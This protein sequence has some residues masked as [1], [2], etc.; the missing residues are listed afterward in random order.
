MTNSLNSFGARSSLD[1]E[2]RSL[3]YFSL[4]SPAL[5]AFGVDRLPYSIKVLLENLLRHE[6][7][8]KVRADDVEAL[9]RWAETPTRHGEAAGDD[10]R[11]IAFTP[12]RVLMQDLTGVPAVVD[13][14]SMRDAIIAL[15]GD[16]AKIN[17]LVPVELVID[18]SVILEHTGT[19]ESYEENVAIEYDRNVERYTFLKW[20]QSSF[21]QFRVVPPGMGI[22]HQVNLE[23]LARVV[24]ENDGVAYL[25]T[26]VGTDS[27]TTMVNGLGVLGWG[28]GGIEAEAGMLGQPTSM[29][30]PP[31]VGLRLSGA[32][33]EGVTATD[34]VLTITELLRKHGVVGKFVEAY[35][36]GVASLS[37]ETRATIGNMSPEYGATCAIF[38]IDQVT[39]DYLKFTGRP[40]SQL[41]LVEAY[42]KA[43]GLWHD[44]NAVEPVYSEHVELDLS[45]VEPSLA[46]PKR[47]Q[48]RVSLSGARGAFRN[49][50][51]REPIEVRGI[52]A[53]DHLRDG[54]VTVAA[55]TSCTN[56]SNPAVLV[57]AG[58]VAKRAVEL[59]LTA[60]PWVKTSLAPGSRVVMDYLERADLVGPLDQLGFYLAGYGCTTCIGNTGPLLSGVSEAVNEHD[61]SVVSVLSGNR[62]FE[63]RIHPDVKQNFLASPPLVVAYAL[64][65]TIDI[66]LSSEPLGQGANGEP[67]FLADLW[68]TDAQVAEAVRSSVTPEM[69]EE[70]YASAFSGDLRWQGVPTTN[71]VTYAWDDQSTYVKLP[72]YFEGLTMEPGT[73]SD[74]SGVRVLAKLGDS[75]TTDHISPAG[76]IRANVPAGRYLIDGGIEPSDF[77]SYGTR[78]GNHE[79]MVRGTFANIRLRNQMA[80]GTEG[81]VSVK[82]PEGTQMSIFDAAMAYAQEGTPLM[83]IGGKEYGSGSSR[84]WAAKGTK[85]LGVKA[86]LVESFERIH[87]SNLVGMG[88]LPLQFLTGE[89]ASTYGLDGTETFSIA[90]LDPLNRGETVPRVRLTATRSDGEEVE[91]EVRLRIDTPTEA[92]YY[93]HGGVLNFVLRQLA[94]Q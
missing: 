91:F 47:P 43:Q 44:G 63:G 92:D 6:D 50:L 85:L 55:I 2:G 10:A 39:V 73:V 32:T 90:G 58:L 37:L 31:V 26:V 25:D 54:D 11:E 42:A 64:A 68:P 59:G 72:P 22:C 7:G 8:V 66:D 28:V 74:L 77:N 56:T 88:V 1:V 65:G 80:P 48:D 60:K 49:A 18:H 52:E 19:P 4:K 93:R 76:N 21:K 34:V 87:R 45:T 70:R 94:A 40:K 29:L 67:V 16:P 38:P 82:L 20:A 89:S 17:P 71:A 13:L 12:E 3:T 75:V 35:G 78:R 69:F 84:D 62:N 30:I 24:F 14:A 9:A 33:R 41:D 5:S 53:A 23:H 81:G 15:G 46:G 51:G 83:I 79:V 57:A 36:P 27:H 61:L 86:V